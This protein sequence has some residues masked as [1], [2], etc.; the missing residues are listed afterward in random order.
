MFSYPHHLETMFQTE[1]VSIFKR[2][3]YKVC[4]TWESDNSK[5][6]P[7]YQLFM[8][9]LEWLH[10]SLSSKKSTLFPREWRISLFYIVNQSYFFP[11]SQTQPIQVLL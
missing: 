6:S 1:K 2:M 11:M 10:M 9:H 3:P 7:V 8:Q 4:N 5:V